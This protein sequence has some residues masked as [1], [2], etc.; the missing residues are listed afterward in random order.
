MPAQRG[1]RLIV[2]L[3]LMIW[4]GSQ[5]EPIDV[6]LS[7]NDTVLTAVTNEALEHALDRSEGACLMIRRNTDDGLDASYCGT[8]NFCHERPFSDST[9]TH[10]DA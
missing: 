8:L 5:S 2:V 9:V 6:L 7:F 10:V 4:E 1:N 3:P